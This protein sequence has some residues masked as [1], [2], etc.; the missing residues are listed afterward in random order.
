MTEEVSSQK[1]VITLKKVVLISPLKGQMDLN[2]VNK[3]RNK[4]K[5]S[6]CEGQWLFFPLNVWPCSYNASRQL[7]ILNFRF[8]EPITLL[9]NKLAF[10]NSVATLEVCGADAKDGGLY[11]CE[12]RN[13]AG[14]ESCSMELRV[15]GQS[16]WRLTRSLCRSWCHL[17][18]S[19][20][21]CFLNCEVYLQKG[22][23]D[24]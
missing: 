2:H 13:E 21:V 19:L 24:L 23:V 17:G 10:V 1:K 20:S 11:Y 6:Y 18:F 9:N 16:C 4:K 12:A 3:N 15:K 5:R 14:S 7:W 8:K 22:A